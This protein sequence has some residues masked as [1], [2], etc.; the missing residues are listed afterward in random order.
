M[1]LIKPRPRLIILKAKTHI[2][3]RITFFERDLEEIGCIGYQLSVIS[4]WL[5]VISY[6]SF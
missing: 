5:L 1:V 4:Y 2:A 3:P 6:L